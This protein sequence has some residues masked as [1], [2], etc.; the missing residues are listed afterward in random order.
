MAAERCGC[1]A[2][3]V[4]AVRYDAFGRHDTTDCF[5]GKPECSSLAPLSNCQVCE[6]PLARRRS[7]FC[8][9]ACYAQ[10]KFKG[11][12]TVACPCG[13]EFEGR[14]WHVARGKDKYCSV[15]CATRYRRRHLGTVAS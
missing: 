6:A 15:V 11:R 3:K 5:E 14:P 13:V 9:H 1:G 2:W 8:S 4:P 10:G 12:V 7:R